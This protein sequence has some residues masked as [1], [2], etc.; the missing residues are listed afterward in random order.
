MRKPRTIFAPML[1]LL[2]TL[3]AQMSIHAQNSS[4]QLDAEMKRLY[5]ESKFPGFCVAVVNKDRIL[6]QNGFGFAD[7]DKRIPYTTGTVQPVGSVSKTLIGVALMKAVEQN[8]FTL[9][10]NINDLLPFKVS[11]PH[12]PARAIKVK[13]LATHTSGILDREEVY[14]KTYVDG[15]NTDSTVK[16]FLFAYLNDKGKFYSKSN[17]S[18]NAPGA[19]FH[20]TNIGA[21]LDAYVIEAKSGMSYADYTRKHI[22]DPLRM[23]G[24]GWLLNETSL[25]HAKLY[26]AKRKPYPTYT[27][28]TYPDGGLR[29]SCGDLSTYLVEI[30]K[31]YAGRSELLKAKSFQTMLSPQFTAKNP[32]RNI[33]PKEPNQGIFWQ[34]RRNGSIG[35]S[36]SDPGVGAFIVFDPRREL[37]RIFITNMDIEDAQAAA[38][39]ATIWKTLESY[40]DKLNSNR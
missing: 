18:E 10:T 1:M 25:A 4:R 38:Q 7:A 29:T 16:D 36:G 12:S 9:E 33:D 2:A 27:S 8:H 15:T 39:F 28:I 23:N 13:H 3:V 19:D 17:F 32:P 11:S 20:Y 21:T 14:A 30:I 22:L 40:E 5:A 24:S 6:Y 37:G 31:G 34:F 35:H 26:D